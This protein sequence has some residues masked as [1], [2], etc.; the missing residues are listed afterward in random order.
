VIERCAIFE[1]LLAVRQ[2]CRNIF[3]FSALQAYTEEKEEKI[4]INK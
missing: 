2:R 3:D 4:Q 1:S